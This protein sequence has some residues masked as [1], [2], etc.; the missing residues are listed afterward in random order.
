MEPSGPSKY[1]PA[2]LPDPTSATAEPLGGGV[3]QLQGL[4]EQIRTDPSPDQDIAYRAGGPADGG[5]RPLVRELE[6]PP[7][8]PVPAETWLSMWFYLLTSKG[9]V[10]HIHSRAP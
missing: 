9:D 1:S 5:P 2:G 10:L 3:G 7:G 4:D 6:A 8:S